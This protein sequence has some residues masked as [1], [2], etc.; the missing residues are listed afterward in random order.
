M[1]RN[2]LAGVVRSSTAPAV[3]PVIGHHDCLGA[4]LVLALREG[5]RPDDRGRH[6]RV[7]EHER[8]REVGERATGGG[9]EREQLLDE[10]ELAFPDRV[11]VVEVLWLARG[12]G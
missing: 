2:A 5:P 7:P 6:G 1:A 9:R 10:I 12:A 4:G 3:E 8:E 11:V